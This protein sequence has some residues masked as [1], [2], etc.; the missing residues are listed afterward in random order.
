MCVGSGGTFTK[1]GGGTIYGN[2]GGTES[3]VVRTI[4]SNAGTAVLVM[5]SGTSAIGR[6]TTAGTSQN[7]NSAVAGSGGGWEF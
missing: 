2:N 7:L 3:N 1:M 6:N 4:A 5:R